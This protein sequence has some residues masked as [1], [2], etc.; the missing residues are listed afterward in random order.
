MRLS[1]FTDLIEDEFGADFA[2]VITHDTSLISLS[3][4]TPKQLLSEGEDPGLVWR[5]I[6][7]QLGVPKERWHGKP[8]IKRHAE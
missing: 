3:D 4:K 2:K 8:K 7:E 1:Q 5:A 6:C